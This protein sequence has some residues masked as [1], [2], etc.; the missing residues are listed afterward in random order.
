MNQD[1]FAVQLGE[2]IRDAD[3]KEAFYKLYAL[4]V[5]TDGER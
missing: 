4:Y 1:V 3:P 2:A 5:S